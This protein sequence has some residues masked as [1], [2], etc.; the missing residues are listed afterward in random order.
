MGDFDNITY[1]YRHFLFF[2]MEMTTI[3]ILYHL[4]SQVEY[5]LLL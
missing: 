4:Y 3:L 1:I 2:H 5:T